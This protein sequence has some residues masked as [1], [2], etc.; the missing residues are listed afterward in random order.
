MRL[1]ASLTVLENS[2]DDKLG[3]PFLTGLKNLLSLSETDGDLARTLEEIELLV[4]RI[5]EADKCSIRLFDRTTAKT[6]RFGHADGNSVGAASQVNPAPCHMNAGDSIANR[7]FKTC[8]NRTPT[9]NSAI[10]NALVAHGMTIGV[11]TVHGYRGSPEFT[12]LEEMMLEIVAVVVGNSLKLVHMQNLLKL[13]YR[14]AV[15]RKCCPIE[16]AKLFYEDLQKAGFDSG[17]VVLAASEIISQVSAQLRAKLSP[18]HLPEQ[19]SE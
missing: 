18:T 5:F 9:S 17:A 13:R 1:E 7:E 15:F 4:A 8:H 14:P 12:G 6:L 19:I 2:R 10:S 3:S 11:I 16:L